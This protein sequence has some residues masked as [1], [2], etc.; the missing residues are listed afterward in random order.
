MAKAAM[1]AGKKA[2]GTFAKAAANLTLHRPAKEC[3]FSCFGL[4][5]RRRERTSA[6]NNPFTGRSASG[7]LF[8]ACARSGKDDAERGSWLPRQGGHCAASSHIAFWQ[9]TVGL[10]PRSQQLRNFEP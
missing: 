7:A 5:G 6:I 1:A 3:K 10:H 2:T 9:T 4:G 8:Y